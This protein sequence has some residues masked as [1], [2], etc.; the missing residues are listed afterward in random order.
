V[1]TLGEKIRVHELAREM[2]ITSKRVME[3]LEVLG[4]PVK[5]HSSTLADEVAQGVRDKLR[6]TRAAQF[7][8]E[9]HIAVLCVK[10][11]GIANAEANAR[12]FGL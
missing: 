2:G 1:I 11:D 4:Q 6:S 3:V 10:H 9:V 5:S 8:H 7:K 12:S